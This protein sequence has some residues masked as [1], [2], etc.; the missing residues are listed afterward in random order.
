MRVVGNALDQQPETALALEKILLLLKPGHL[1]S[2]TGRN[3][4]TRGTVPKK[5]KAPERGRA[6]NIV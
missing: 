5:D 2:K 1:P 3:A 6:A 4:F